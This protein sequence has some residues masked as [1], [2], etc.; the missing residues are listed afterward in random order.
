MVVKTFL[1]GEVA[2]M[3]CTIYT[4]WDYDAA[5]ESVVVPGMRR[6]NKSQPVLA[7]DVEGNRCPVVGLGA[8]VTSLSQSKS[9]RFNDG[10]G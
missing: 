4:D 9:H 8:W 10:P 7:R 1:G 6:C 2:W 3:P 5:N